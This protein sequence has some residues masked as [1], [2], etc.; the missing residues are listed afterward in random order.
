[1]DGATA[2]GLAP[3]R[4][5]RY[6]D[7]AAAA[8]PVARLV[9]PGDLVLVKGSRGTRTDVIADRLARAAEVV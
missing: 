1:M 6:A 4:I 2:A 9:A 7:S 8:E 3:A 5:H